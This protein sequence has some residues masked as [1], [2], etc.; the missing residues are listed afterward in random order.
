MKQIPSSS[1]VSDQ[2][3]VEPEPNI[4]QSPAK[5]GRLSSAAPATK[6]GGVATAPE[7]VKE[8]ESLTDHHEIIEKLE[9]KIPPWDKMSTR[10]QKE[11]DLVRLKVYGSTKSELAI[12]PSRFCANELVPCSEPCGIYTVQEVM[13]AEH[14]QWE[15][16][17][18]ADR[19]EMEE[20]AAE[21]RRR[22]S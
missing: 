5:R 20:D 13:E 16:D 9:L 18:E 15:E 14:K 8:R 2:A 10:T 17:D 6:A 21:K 12:V 19:R 7:Q 22:V 3:N 4:A 1:A 11:R